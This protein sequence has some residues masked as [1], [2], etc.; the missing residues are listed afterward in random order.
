M[1]SKARRS[2]PQKLELRIPKRLDVTST[3]SELSVIYLLSI[4]TVVTVLK[5]TETNRPYGY[6]I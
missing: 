1:D 2:A 6:I 5:L 4:L 3:L